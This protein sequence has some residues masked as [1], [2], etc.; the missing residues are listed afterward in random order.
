MGFVWEL[1][2][3]HGRRVFKNNVQVQWLK[4][5]GFAADIRSRCDHAGLESFDPI[6]DTSLITGKFSHG[7]DW[8]LQYTRHGAVERV[9]NAII[10]Q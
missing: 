6:D 2:I 9:M 4:G 10:G 5:L 7:L 3:R 1:H 8:L